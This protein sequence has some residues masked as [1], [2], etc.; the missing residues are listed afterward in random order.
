MSS[1]SLN[2]QI[3]C[4]IFVFFISIFGFYIPIYLA[5]CKL[6]SSLP[7]SSSS[8]SSFNIFNYFQRILLSESFTQYIYLFLKCCG[9]GVI[10]GVALVHLLADAVGDLS[11]Y[12]EYPGKLLSYY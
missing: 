7:S 6:T 10:L 1:Y 5:Y 12:Y 4:I 3:F 9:S 2:L 8:S 11:E